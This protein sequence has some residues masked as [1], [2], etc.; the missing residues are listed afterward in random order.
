MTVVENELHFQQLL[1]QFNTMVPRVGST[2]AGRTK[3]FSI[4]FC[5]SE[6]IHTIFFVLFCFLVRISICKDN[7]V[8]K[9]VHNGVGST[10]VLSTNGRLCRRKVWEP[11][12]W[13]KAAGQCWSHGDWTVVM[14]TAYRSCL[15]FL[16]DFIL[17]YC[18]H[19]EFYS[20]FFLHISF[21]VL[22]TRYNNY[23]GFFFFWSLAERHAVK[24]K[25]VCC[26]FFANTWVSKS[27][28]CF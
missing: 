6:K 26:L 10:I 4:C 23:C 28:L 16:R 13:H 9:K 1:W 8:F 12:G 22:S 18:I 14:K 15:L 21:R 19:V 5:V 20:I 17:D 24:Y 3:H 2:G 7:S 27:C 25:V 11:L